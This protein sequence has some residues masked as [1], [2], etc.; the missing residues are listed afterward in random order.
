MSDPVAGLRKSERAL[1][2]RVA[3]AA[4]VPPE[5]MALAMIGAY[6]QLLRDAPAALP[7]DPLKGLGARARAAR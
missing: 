7:H 5:D 3:A 1:L 4:E 6:L 2:E